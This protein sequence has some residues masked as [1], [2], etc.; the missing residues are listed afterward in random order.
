MKSFVEHV[1]YAIVKI[2]AFIVCRLPVPV[3]LALGR[4]IGVIGYYL[5]RK[6]KA[7][8]Y[9]NLKIAFAK[10]KKP[11]EIKRIVKRIFQN[12]GQ[13]LIE[14]LRLPLVSRL[15]PE[16]FVKIEGRENVQE[17]LKKQKGLILLAMHFGSWEMSSL[18]NALVGHPYRVVA[19][20]QN[21]FSKLDELLNSYRQC[22]GTNV[23]SRGRG[24]REIIESLRNNEIIGMVVDQGGRDGAL[25]KF[26]GRLASMSVG[27]I[28]M[29]LKLDV[30]ICFSIILRDRDAQHRLVIHPVL[31]LVKTGNMEKDV[32][33]NLNKIVAVMERYIEQY[34]SEY[35]WFYKIWKYSKEATAVIL[36]DGKAGHLRQ[37]QAVAKMVKAA[38]ADRGIQCDTQ[39]VDVHFKNRLCAKMIAFLSLLSHPFFC[40]GR[41][42]YLK[43]FLTRKSFLDIVSVKA[44]FVVSCG[45][46]VAAVN[47]FLS[48]DYRAKTISILKPGILS[49]RRFDLVVLPWH[50]NPSR[51]KIKGQVVCVQGA[52]NLI[53][54]DYLKEQSSL[55]VNHFPHLRGAKEIKIGVLLGGD[56][57]HHFLGGGQIKIL[58]N[59]IKNACEQNNA[60]VL[61]TTSRRTSPAVENLLQREIKN[62]PRCRLLILANRNNA[63]EAVGGILGLCDIL[64]VSG[65][66]VSMVS[67]AASSGKNVIVFPAQRNKKRFWGKDKHD[68]FIENLHNYGHI[69]LS[70][71]KDISQIIASMVRNKIR[72]KTLN[73]N[74]LILEA[75][76]EII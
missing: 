18:M 75:A 28:K 71:E 9:A 32:V 59:Q 63:P 17:A 43:W 51:R 7:L 70:N 1:I 16:K 61:V 76:R 66:S 50:D 45:S 56:T 42:R 20:P 69:V 19:K 33:S 40:Q 23:I 11:S 47:F 41:L 31:E 64:V 44:D 2:I 27:A 30:P 74:A 15:G 48:R 39:T 8:A 24:T 73:D 22:G 52:P 46:S 14:L 4:M 10:T 67:E 37:S 53:D 36:N 26:F 34:P 49:F 13:N 54:K 38:L 57:K 58:I 62:Y 72:T 25:V 21:R 55:L 5:D 29:G 6:H 68:V 35:M 60:D 65:D 12:Y 3:A